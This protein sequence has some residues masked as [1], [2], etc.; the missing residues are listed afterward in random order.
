M[1]IAQGNSLCYLSQKN[2]NVIFF[3]SSFFLYKIR[4]CEGGTC[5]ARG[6]LPMG[7]GRQ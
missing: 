7:V 5:P 3:F 2:N 1:E 6:V 4:E